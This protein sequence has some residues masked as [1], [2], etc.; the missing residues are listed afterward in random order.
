MR[1]NTGGTRSGQA[2]NARQPRQLRKLALAALFLLAA[3]GQ[4]E[5]DSER[6]RLANEANPAG[7]SLGREPLSRLVVAGSGGF[8]AAAGIDMSLP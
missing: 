2:R 4:S 8:A 1:L 5:T 6:D 3:C 7:M